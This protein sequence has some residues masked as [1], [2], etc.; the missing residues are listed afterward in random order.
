MLF[1]PGNSGLKKRNKEILC[2]FFGLTPYAPYNVPN[3]IVI[4]AFETLLDILVI[5]D[6]FFPVIIIRLDAVVVFGSHFSIAIIAE[7]GTVTIRT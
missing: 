2:A 1:H 7:F 4:D 5:I 3:R 6:A